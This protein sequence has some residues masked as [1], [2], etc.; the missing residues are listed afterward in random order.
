MKSSAATTLASETVPWGIRRVKGPLD[1]AGNTAWV[2]DSG[3]DLDHP[4]L[5]VDTN[6]SASFISGESADDFNGH[7]THVAGILAAIDNTREVVG[8]AAGATVVSV[9]VLNQ[10]LFATT[11][12]ICN[13]VDYVAT[14]AS[15]ND[16]IN[17]SIEGP[18]DASIDQAVIDAADMGF[19]FAIAAGNHGIHADSSSPGRVEHANV[20][21]MS[22]YDDT[23]T[24]AS[25]SNFGNPP[26][27]YGG[28]GVD[29]PSLAIGGGITN[30]SGTSQATPHI[31]G[32]LLASVAGIDTD[33]TVS[34]DPDGTPDPIGVKA[35]S[36]VSVFISGPTFV[37]NGQQGEWT[38]E[39]SGGFPPYSY[40]WF[41]SNTDPTW[42][43]QAG[44]G[45]SYS[46]TV[47]ESFDL[48]VEV[49][50]QSQTTVSDVHSVA[51]N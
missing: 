5:N 15:T 6:N 18:I 22:A 26:I 7:G 36:D 30:K 46:E 32:L 24:F 38:A 42:W 2:L 45:S 44:T 17:M 16:V 49:T 25:F 43:Q 13:G 12:S 10:N 8:V 40:Q 28:P 3:I 21:T 19:R 31:A 34:S 27:E 37:T 23:D 35:D 33:G 29:V 11:T 48:K 50:D 39:V 20:W 14:Q 9:K 1:G 41:R 4:D 51:T 47:T